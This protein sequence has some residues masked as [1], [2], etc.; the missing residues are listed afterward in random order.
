MVKK[1]IRKGGAAPQK[2]NSKLGE[3]AA[4]R[5]KSKLAGIQKRKRAASDEIVSDA[6]DEPF[7]GKNDPFLV[8]P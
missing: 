4:K 8:D 7:D 6:S 2:A 3:S 1:T 5:M